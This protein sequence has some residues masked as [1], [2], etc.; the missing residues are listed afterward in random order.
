VCLEVFNIVSHSKLLQD[1][2]SEWHQ[3]KIQ[4]MLNIGKWKLYSRLGRV[5]T[6]SAITERTMNI[7]HNGISTAV[8]EKELCR[9]MQPTEM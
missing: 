7:Y 2:Q 1:A 8:K 4:Q 5:E 6:T 3:E 9:K